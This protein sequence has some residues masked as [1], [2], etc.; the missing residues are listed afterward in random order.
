M[1]SAD[2]ETGMSEDECLDIWAFG[3]VVYCVHFSRRYVGRCLK[4]C[5]IV[6][7]LVIIINGR[8]FSFFVFVFKKTNMNENILRACI[9]NRNTVCYMYKIVK[10]QKLS[11]G[12]SAFRAK[13]KG[14]NIET[15][16]LIKK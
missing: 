5:E 13:R 14:L 16:K 8:L 9:K 3:I 7:I 15:N 6:S 1:Q 10:T 4:E 11:Y 2:H 12:I